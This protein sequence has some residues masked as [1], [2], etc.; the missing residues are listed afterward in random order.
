MQCK[1]FDDSFLDHELQPIFIL[2]VRDRA[3]LYLSVLG[4]DGTVDT[5]KESKDF[6]FG[7]LEVPLVNMETS[8]KNYVSY[9]SRFSSFQYFL[10]HQLSYIFDP[11][12]AL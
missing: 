6:L 10:G 1:L 4:G 5:D 7:S 2:K 12:G 8:L 11:A 9:L 3:T